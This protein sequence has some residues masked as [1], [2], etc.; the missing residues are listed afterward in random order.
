MNDQAV[1]APQPV[2][3]YSEHLREAK[4]LAELRDGF[5]SNLQILVATPG[6]APSPRSPEAVLCGTL[7]WRI[8]R[9]HARALIELP[10]SGP[11]AAGG[12]YL[13]LDLGNPRAVSILALAHERASG[14]PIE[15]FVA[16]FRSALSPYT[17]GAS[18]GLTG[19]AEPAHRAGAVLPLAWAVD[20][21]DFEAAGHAVLGFFHALAQAIGHPAGAYFESTNVL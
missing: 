7:R 17:L 11:L 5:F 15:E 13:E 1:G 18:P 8:S 3:T 20:P 6:L 12:A 14:Q 19:V 4:R 2:F 21:M 9:L 16:A 10:G